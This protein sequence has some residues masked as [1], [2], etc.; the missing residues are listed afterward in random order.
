MYGLSIVFLFVYGLAVY[1]KFDKLKQISKKLLKQGSL[2]LILFNISNIS[3]SAGIHWKYA[4]YN[5]NNNGYIVS[6]VFMYSTLL[7]VIINI[8]AI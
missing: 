3:Y 7:I 2:I 5:T 4:Q 8:I 1:C 6:T